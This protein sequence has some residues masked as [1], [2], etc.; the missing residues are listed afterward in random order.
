MFL[1]DGQISEYLQVQDRGLHYGDGVFETIA[2]L[3]NSLL[4]WEAHYQRLKSGCERL[5]I[6]CPPASILISDFSQL[7]QDSELAVLKI[8][9]TRGQGGRGY[10]SPDPET[11]V[12][13]ILGIYPWPDYP[14]KNYAEGVNTRICRMRL[15]HNPYLAGIKHLNRLEQVLARSEWDQVDIAEGLMLDI[16]D[17]VIEGTMSNLFIVT[18]NSLITSDIVN[19]GING[20]IRQFILGL[21]PDVG[22]PVKIT[23]I[24]MQDLYNADEIFLS[25]SV[26]GVWAVKMVESHQ[27][28]PGPWTEKIR[29]KLIEQKIIV[30]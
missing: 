23:T 28:E 18:N 27:F 7:K 21:A 15:G 25:N 3:Q 6:E 5:G 8:I 30:R 9:I 12:T 19:C 24:K 14:E 20:I 10:R 17:N 16:N 4:C 1:I 26:I 22:L 29:N 11:H 2:V 13:R